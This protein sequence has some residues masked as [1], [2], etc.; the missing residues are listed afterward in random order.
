M[1]LISNLTV[2]ETRYFSIANLQITSRELNLSPYVWLI[3]YVHPSITGIY[4][5]NQHETDSTTA[6]FSIC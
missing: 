3:C 4:F 2:K 1:S 6:R 5:I